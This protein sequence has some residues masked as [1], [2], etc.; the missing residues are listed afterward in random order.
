M[1]APVNTLYTLAKPSAL[2]VASLFPVLLKVASKTSSLWPLNVSMHY[3]DPT[4]PDNLPAQIVSHLLGDSEK[5]RTS[6][7]S[8]TSPIYGKVSIRENLVYLCAC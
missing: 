2:A 7:G 3:P 8:E 6:H 1:H 4:S 5:I